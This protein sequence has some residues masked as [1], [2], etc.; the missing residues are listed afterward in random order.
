M[1]GIKAEITGLILSIALVIFILELVRRRRLL[2]EYSLL[3]LFVGAIMMVLAFWKSGLDLVSKAIG[4]AY[5]PSTLFL[6]GLVFIIVLLLH[7]STV[8]SKLT[9]Q[10][11]TLAQKIAILEETKPG[12]KS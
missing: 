3:W 10:N 6:F 8:I 7:F 1:I 4:I 2:E 11:K 12:D 9:E 5:P